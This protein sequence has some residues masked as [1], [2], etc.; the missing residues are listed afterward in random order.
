MELVENE[1]RRKI[2]NFQNL[3]PKFSY[4]YYYHKLNYTY[5]Y[6]YKYFNRYFINILIV[7]K[8]FNSLFNSFNILIV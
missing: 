1:K 7:K 5:A 2:F 6:S 8:Y 4:Y 3:F